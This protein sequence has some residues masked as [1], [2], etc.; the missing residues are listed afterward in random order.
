MQTCEKNSFNQ[1]LKG[2]HSRQTHFCFIYTAQGSGRGINDYV[3][4]HLF[5]EICTV[6]VLMYCIDV[7]TLHAWLL[8]VNIVVLNAD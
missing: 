1:H 4:L 6:T 2:M 8:I 3:L 7:L 5:C